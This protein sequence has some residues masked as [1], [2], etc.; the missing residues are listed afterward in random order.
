MKQRLL[1]LIIGFILSLIVG[2]ILANAQDAGKDCL[3][4]H[5]TEWEAY[6][7][8]SFFP[9]KISAI[10]WET[11]TLYF[12]FKDRSGYKVGS[13]QVISEGSYEP[14]YFTDFDSTFWFVYCRDHKVLWQIVR[15]PK[16]SQ[17]KK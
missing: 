12:L 13:F 8:R 14:N 7:A 6:E 17:R 3:K 5:A 16:L 9:A 15:D 10:N 1:A 11:K 2:T 4:G